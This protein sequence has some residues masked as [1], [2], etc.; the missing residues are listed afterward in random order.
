MILGDCISLMIAPLHLP[1]LVAS[2]DSV[3]LAIT[4]L[5]LYPLCSMK[6][7]APLAKFSLLGVPGTQ[8]RALKTSLITGLATSTSAPSLR[9]VARMALMQRQE[10]SELEYEVEERV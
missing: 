10:P 5:V 3:I 9:C 7:L 2:R 6:S 1:A 4:A 8:F